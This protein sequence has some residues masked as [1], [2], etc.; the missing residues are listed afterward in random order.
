MGNVF[1]LIKPRS[2]GGQR[3]ATLSLKDAIPE[4][5]ALNAELARAIN[6]LLGHF[7][8]LRPAYQ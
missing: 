7:L 8:G 5:L 3:D 6:E 1:Q 4:I 2:F